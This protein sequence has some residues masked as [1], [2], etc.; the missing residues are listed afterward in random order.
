MRLTFFRY[1]ELCLFQGYWDDQSQT[2]FVIFDFLFLIILPCCGSH[3][4]TCWICCVFWYIGKRRSSTHLTSLKKELRK[5]QET[6]LPSYKSERQCRYI[7]DNIARD[8]KAIK[9]QTEIN[10]ISY[11]LNIM[12]EDPCIPAYLS[13]KDIVIPGEFL[14]KSVTLVQRAEHISKELLNKRQQ[15][16]S[17]SERHIG[18]AF[19]LLLTFQIPMWRDGL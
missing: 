19:V 1:P 16:D 17:Q 13:K 3:T 7:S 5:V 9:P 15:Y 4:I 8:L 12:Y 2:I 14:H 10:I 18:I 11:W 6:D